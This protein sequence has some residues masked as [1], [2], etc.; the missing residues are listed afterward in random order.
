M[1]RHGSAARYQLAVS[2]ALPESLVEE[3]RR[4]FGEVSVRSCARETVIEGLVTDHAAVRALAN[5]VWD[6]GSEV[7]LLHVA[8]E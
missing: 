4:R 6:V 8:A 5:L 1:N 7:R 2:G 3:I